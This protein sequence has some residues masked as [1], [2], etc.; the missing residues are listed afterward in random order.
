[1]LATRGWIVRV[2][3]L[4]ATGQ[5]ANQI[6]SLK[7]EWIDDKSRTIL[8]PAS[9]MKGNRDHLIPYGN[10]I[11][12]L[13]KAHQPSSYQGKKKKELDKLSNVVGYTLH[14][15]RRYYS[16]TQRKLKTP[17]DITEA[18][19]SHLSGSRSEIQ[20]IY[21]LYDRIEEMRDAILRYENRLESLIGLAPT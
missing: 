7:R 19:L 6:I 12:P 4:I 2:Q 3:L 15:F 9:I 18:I 8:F 16:S 17:I 13:L 1:M 10:L 14:D 11:A 20:R 21:D 5:R